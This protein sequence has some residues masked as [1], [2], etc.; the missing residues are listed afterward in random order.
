[1]ER[2]GFFRSLLGLAALPFMPIKEMAEK[3]KPMPERFFNPSGWHFSSPV[4]MIITS[5]RCETFRVTWSDSDPW[6]YDNKTA[7]PELA[8]WRDATPEEIK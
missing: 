1:M 2:R 7:S 8:F 4:E 5:G 3:L 6:V